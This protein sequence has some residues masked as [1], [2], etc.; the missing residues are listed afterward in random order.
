MALGTDGQAVTAA[1]AMIKTALRAEGQRRY[2]LLFTDAAADFDAAPLFD[3]MS[4]AGQRFLGADLRPGG[5]LPR[6]PVLGIGTSAPGTIISSDPAHPASAAF[7]CLAGASADWCLP[8]FSRPGA[9][10]A[11]EAYNA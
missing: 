8:E 7:I 11:R 1:Y 9:D 4:A 10:A 6:D 3:R 2:R 5:V